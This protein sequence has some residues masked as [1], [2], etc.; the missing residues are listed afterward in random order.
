MVK[1]TLSHNTLKEII[2]DRPFSDHENYEKFLKDSKGTD[3]EDR[4]K[5]PDV[6]I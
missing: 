4:N 3:G 1:Q 6:A 5:T 2:G